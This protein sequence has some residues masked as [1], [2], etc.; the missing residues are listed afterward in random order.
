MQASER[1]PDATSHGEVVALLDASRAGDAQATGRLVALL[2]GELRA[3]AGQLLRREPT[4]QT[5]QPTALVHEAFLKLIGGG[6]AGWESRA[7]FFGAAARAMRQILVDRARAPRHTLRADQAV[8]SIVFSL[9]DGAGAAESDDRVLR[10]DRAMESLLRMD[11][12]RHEIVMLR[13]FAGLTIEQTAEVLALS[14]S[15]IKAES[16]YARAWLLRE[17]EAA[18]GVPGRARA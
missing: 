18:G 9:D 11:A 10:L 12:R 3:L 17:I 5:L 1:Q 2:H 13:F 14:P 8:E 15:T 4:Q 16:A 7:H 6:V